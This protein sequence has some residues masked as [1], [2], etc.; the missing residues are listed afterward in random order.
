VRKKSLSENAYS[1]IR[2]LIITLELK[3]GS[4]IIE[5][6]QERDLEIGRTPLREAFLRLINEGFLASVPGWGFFVR[7][8]ILDGVRALFEAIMILTAAL[9]L[10]ASLKLR[11]EQGAVEAITEHICHFH[12]RVTKY[13]FSPSEAIRAAHVPYAHRA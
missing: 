13:L 12:T 8:V 5:G 1:K 3:S 2:D 4:K 6:Y 10:A 11:D 7:E 9:L